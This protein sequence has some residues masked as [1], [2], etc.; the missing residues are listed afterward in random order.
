MLS[1]SPGRQ[2]LELMAGISGQIPTKWQA[3]VFD[4]LKMSLNNLSPESNSLP[5]IFF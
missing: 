4:D 2:I 1:L 5:L 3:L